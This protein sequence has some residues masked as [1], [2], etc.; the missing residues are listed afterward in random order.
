M[1]VDDTCLKTQATTGRS[2]SEVHAAACCPRWKVQHCDCLLLVSCHKVTVSATRRDF[3]S[4][5]HDRCQQVQPPF[6]EH[7]LCTASAYEAW[8]C[9]DSVES[10]CLHQH[11]SVV[12]DSQA[13]VRRK[14][15]RSRRDAH[16]LAI[17]TP[18]LF[19]MPFMRRALHRRCIPSTAHPNDQLTIGVTS[20]CKVNQRV[21]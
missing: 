12:I 11:S 6:A 18:D 15:A 7:T 17:G 14:R 9:T 19:E 21:V 5:C 3:A 1:K 16:L 4:S 10:H 13:A 2:V 8:R 20:P